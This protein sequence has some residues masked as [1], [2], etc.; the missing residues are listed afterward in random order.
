MFSFGACT[1]VRTHTHQPLR[2][3]FRHETKPLTKAWP[4]PATFA[5]ARTTAPRKPKRRTGL[6]ITGGLLLAGAAYLRF[7]EDGQFIVGATI[8]TSRVIGTL[9]VS[10]NEYVLS[11]CIHGPELINTTVTGGRYGSMTPSTDR[12]ISNS[13]RIA[14][15]GVPTEH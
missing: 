8:R 14:I 10:V 12:H 13:S 4:R 7:T 15:N 11:D 9:A 3:L 5:T 6:Y 1:R 2:S